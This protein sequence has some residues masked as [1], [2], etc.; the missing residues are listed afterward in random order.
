MGGRELNLKFLLTTNKGE[1]LVGLVGFRVHFPSI[2]YFSKISEM[3]TLMILGGGQMKHVI[4]VPPY[5][6][7]VS[8]LS[9]LN[10]FLKWF[11]GIL[12]LTLRKATEKFQISTYLKKYP[13]KKFPFQWGIQLAYFHEI[14]LFSHITF[15]LPYELYEQLDKF[16][17]KLMQKEMF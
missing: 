2:S 14:C 4:A 17:A 7:C 13:V 11:C 12:C 5:I 15:F 16:L 10:L 8:G 9:S 6:P 3:P 1:G